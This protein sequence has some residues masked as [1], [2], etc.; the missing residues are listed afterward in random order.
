M[1]VLVNPFFLLLVV[2]VVCVSG[3]ALYRKMI[4]SQEDDTV[5]LSAAQTVVVRQQELAQ[6]LEKIDRWGKLITIITAVYG[7]G[8]AAYLIYL[9]WISSSRAGN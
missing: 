1:N 3:L 6:R 9:E 2:M 4:A 5:H 7:V 8:V